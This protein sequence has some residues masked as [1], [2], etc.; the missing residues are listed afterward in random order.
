MAASI[1]AVARISC[2]YSKASAIDG[3]KVN[4]LVIRSFGCYML[5]T[6][7]ESLG[8]EEF[9]VSFHLQGILE[10]P[11]IHP[12]LHSRK[13]WCLHYTV[14]CTTSVFKPCESP[15]TY[16]G[17]VTKVFC[18]KRGEHPTV[19]RVQTKQVRSVASTEILRE[20]TV[21]PL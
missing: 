12:L 5:L 9:Q 2:W 14:L 21:S 17:Y 11:Q 19:L 8:L 3:R 4:R 10:A 7:Q 13:K 1:F 16:H 20:A 15:V 18:S 6:V